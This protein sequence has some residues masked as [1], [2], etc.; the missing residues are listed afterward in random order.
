VIIAAA[1]GIRAAPGYPDRHQWLSKAALITVL[2]G[3]G[4]CPACRPTFSQ[5]AFLPS[6]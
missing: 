6:P 5:L 1:I 4:V 3:L 2:L